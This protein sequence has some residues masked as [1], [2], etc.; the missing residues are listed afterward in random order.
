MKQVS[1]QN[2]Q[3]RRVLVT[4]GAGF[5]GSHLVE[6]LVDSGAEVTIV[7]NLRSGRWENISRVSAKVRAIESDVRNTFEI[8][9]VVADAKPETLIHLAAN[10]SVPESVKNPE[11]D[12]QTNC[13]GT[14]NILNAIRGLGGCEKAIILS[15]GTVY[16]EPGSI[17]IRE[18][19]PL[20]PI[21][22]YG[23]SKLHAEVTAGMYYRVYGVPTV[24]ARLFNAYGPR[25]G[26]FVILD[27]LYKLRQNPDRLEILGTGRQVRE[28]T[29][30][31]DIVDGL[32]LL[33]VSGEPGQSYN[34]SSGAPCT[35]ADLATKIVQIVVLAG[36]TDL[37]FTGESWVGDAQRWE[38]SLDKIHALGFS[39]SIDLDEGL[40]RVVQWFK[41]TEGEICQNAH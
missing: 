6:R 25:M 27:F 17:P 23:A 4:G 36:K 22:P 14:F 21:S 34:I 13:L 11:Y 30:V 26:R 29:Y 33:A 20:V 5:I 39:P 10:A 19:D 40:R 8:E 2:W 31:T 1:H 7:D 32:L 16:G 18:S 9:K 35:V 28:F 38:V 37:S 24:C 12:F 3:N 41:E 15:S